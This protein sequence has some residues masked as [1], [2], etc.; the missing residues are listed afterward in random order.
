MARGA[1]SSIACFTAIILGA[2]V[3][4]QTLG[5]DFTGLYSIVDLGALP[6]VPNNLGCMIFKLDDTNTLLI[7]G[8]A[9]GG[10]GA[11]YQIQVTRDAQ[12]HVTGFAGSGVL[13]GQA[14]NNDGGITYGSTGA[15]LISR[16]PLNQVGQSR[17]GSTTT[18]LISDL[19]P[20]GVTGSI[21]GVSFVPARQPGAGRLKAVSY[22]SA[23][24][25]NLAFT[26][27][28]DGLYDITGATQ[29]A[30]LQG[31]PEGFV[32]V[33]SCSPGFTA[34]AIL[35]CEYGSGAVTTY[36]VDTNG[37]PIPSARRIFISG[38]NGAEGCVIDPVT[39][40]FLFTTYGGGNRIIRISGFPPPANC[41]CDW[42]GLDCLNSQ[43]FFDFLSDFF[44]G[45]ADFN[46]S[47]DTNS[48]DFFD[49]LTCFFGGCH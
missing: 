13:Y 37:D 22:S 3:H 27:R 20:L 8:A 38:L 16:Y 32:Y 40:D 30:P 28:P 12:N 1:A 6:G 31:G 9:N 35:Q 19:T 43:D 10:S 41:P 7:G 33:P 23:Q 45:H 14:A 17:P 42:N 44:A 36:A 24:F 21:G 11:L 49:F 15:L 46:Q 4:A 34:P 2:N 25:Y 47:G 26:Q 5:P 39:G 18:D 48:Q 29:T